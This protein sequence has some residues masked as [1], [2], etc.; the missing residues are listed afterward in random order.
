LPNMVIYVLKSRG[1][2]EK[3]EIFEITYH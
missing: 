3:Y 1:V 2:V